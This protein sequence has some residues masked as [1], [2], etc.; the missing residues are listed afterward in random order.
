MRLNQN[1]RKYDDIFSQFDFSCALDPNLDPN[2]K[3]M[4]FQANQYQY[5]RSK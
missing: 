2:E 1:Y 5:S 4:K 3:K